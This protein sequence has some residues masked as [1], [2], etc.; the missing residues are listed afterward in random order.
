MMACE[1]CGSRRKNKSLIEPPRK[2]FEGIDASIAG[3]SISVAA[4]VDG[5]CAIYDAVEISCCP[6]CG[7]K[8][9]QA[10]DSEV[11]E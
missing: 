4:W 10:Q 7:R 6:M 3:G 2:G 11:V 1:Y 8:L 9:N 5:R